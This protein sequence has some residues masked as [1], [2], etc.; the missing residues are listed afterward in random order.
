MK[1]S[2]SNI[3]GSQ[4]NLFNNGTTSSNLINENKCKIVTLHDNTT[5]RIQNIFSK[6]GIFLVSSYREITF[7]NMVKKIIC[8]PTEEYILTMLINNK[9]IINQ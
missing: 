2:I 3:S 8:H 4:S 5:I 1:K 7:T 6:T 9:L